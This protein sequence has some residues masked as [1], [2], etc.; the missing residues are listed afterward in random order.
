MAQGICVAAKAQFIALAAQRLAGEFG[1]ISSGTLSKGNIAFRKAV[2][3]YLTDTFKISHA[4][5][6]TAY[7][8]AK[9]QVT[10]EQP[11]LVVGLG[12]AEDKKGGRKP[13]SKKVVLIA[14]DA[15]GETVAEGTSVDTTAETATDAAPVETV[16]EEVQVP[17]VSIVKAPKA[18]S[19]KVAKPKATSKKVAETV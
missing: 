1:D 19:K 6:C 5:A 9:E 4:S 16:A 3:L 8:W 10:K 12:R 15:A 7:N 18:T 14:P 2:N 13:G 17:A 11:E